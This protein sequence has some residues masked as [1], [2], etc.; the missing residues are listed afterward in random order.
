V[1]GG[2]RVVSGDSVPDLEDC[3]ESFSFDDD[4]DGEVPDPDPD[5]SAFEGDEVGWK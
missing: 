5:S 3:D 2:F 1:G 4:P